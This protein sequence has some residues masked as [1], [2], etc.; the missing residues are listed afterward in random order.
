MKPL[1]WIQ[2][3]WDLSSFSDA[4]PGLP[5]HYEIGPV[6]TENETELRK[7][8]SSV[9]LLDPAWNPAIAE[10]MQTIQP[11]LDRVFGSETTT[12][13]ALR[14]GTRMI[15]ATVISTEPGA[16]SHLIPGPCV[17]MEYRNRGFGTALLKASFERL[18]DAGIAKAIGITR[19]NTPVTK[20]LYPKFGGIASAV[21]VSTLLAA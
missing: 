19:A 10:T 5:K 15:G 20:F 12:C 17:L 21:N 18:R 3:S 2:F 11:W 13:L 14:H 4:N 6:S 1:N 8:F 7:V 16:D 9:F